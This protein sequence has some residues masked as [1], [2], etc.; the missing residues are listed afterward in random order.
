MLEGVREK[1]QRLQG[2]IDKMIEKFEEETDLM[3]ENV[4][5]NRVDDGLWNDFVGCEIEVKF[6]PISDLR[7]EGIVTVHKQ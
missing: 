3:I 6:R 7:R 4:H 5:I 1:I 2:R